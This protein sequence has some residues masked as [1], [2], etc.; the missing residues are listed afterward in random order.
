[1][2]QLCRILCHICHA[3]WSHV[4]AVTMTPHLTALVRHFMAFS[5]HY[6]LVRGEE[7]DLLS[8]LYR[9]I[10]PALSI[11][12]DARNSEVTRDNGMVK[13]SVDDGRCHFV[14]GSDND[15]AISDT[16]STDVT[17]TVGLLSRENSAQDQLPTDELAPIRR[18]SESSL[19]GR[20]ENTTPLIGRTENT[21]PL[22]GRD[23]DK[24]LTR[25]EMSLCSDSYQ[26]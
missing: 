25:L 12:A 11:A 8:D 15:T 6:R 3:H 22:I 2:T 16:A 10:A 9:Q 26:C 13:S 17:V 14:I 1:M 23:M 5:A 7:L 19:I 4:I 24:Q 21:T 18:F 20:V